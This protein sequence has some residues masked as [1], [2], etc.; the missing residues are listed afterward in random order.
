[1]RYQYLVQNGSQPESNDLLVAQRVAEQYVIAFPTHLPDGT[2]SR[3]YGWGNETGNNSF[4]WCDDVFMGLTLV[5]RLANFFQKAE[6]GRAVQQ[7]CRDRSR[8]PSSA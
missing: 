2:F 3:A 6:I 1:M 7:E 4:L 5:N 8:M